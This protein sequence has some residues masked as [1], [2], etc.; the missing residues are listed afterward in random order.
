[1][2]IEHHLPIPNTLAL[3]ARAEQGVFATTVREVMEAR[4]YAE[5]RG[6]V[7]VP[8]GEGSNIVPHTQV[9]SFVCVMRLRGI[10]LLKRSN[11]L[12]WVKVAAGENWHDFVLYCLEQSWFGLEN[13]AL[14]PGSVGAAP[15]QNI[16]A[17]GADV[18]EFID[19]VEVL[20]TKG[21]REV[22]RG[23]DCNFTYRDS[24]FKQET[25]LTILS[26]TFRLPSSPQLMLDYPDLRAE[27]ECT[28]GLENVT[29]RDVAQAVT[30]IRTKKLPAPAAH[31]N[32]GSFFKNPRVAVGKAQSLQKIYPELKFYELDDDPARVKMSAAQLIDQL[33]WKNKPASHVGCWQKQPLVLVNLGGASSDEVLDFA[34]AIQ[35]DVK[36]QCGVYLEL[37]PS[38][39]S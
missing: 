34:A 33:G 37:E 28:T 6:L 21:A 39:L 31:P 38:V 19:V 18:S 36:R 14:I 23:D 30:A 3:E 5:S 25:G 17:Y 27:L 22:W 15:V 1:M 13:L 29:P 35:K 10:E 9:T 24:R 20:N 2:R 4:D 32:V 8:V 26:V 11:G 12:I 16:G 7:F